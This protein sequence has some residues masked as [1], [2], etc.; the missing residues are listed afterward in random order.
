M[1]A[2]LQPPSLDPKAPPPIAGPS[3][4][5]RQMRWWGLGLFLFG[6]IIAV[7]SGQLSDSPAVRLAGPVIGMVGMVLYLGGTVVRAFQW[8]RE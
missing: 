3:R 1:T 4:L 6:L 2:P 7:L 8:R 5:V